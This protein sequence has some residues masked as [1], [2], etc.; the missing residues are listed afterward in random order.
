MKKKIVPIK[1][2]IKEVEKLSKYQNLNK[3]VLNKFSDLTKSQKDYI[4]KISTNSIKKKFENNNLSIDD[5]CK[6]KDLLNEKKNYIKYENTINDIINKNYEN[7]NFR[8]KLRQRKI[9]AIL[10]TGSLIAILSS[11]LFLNNKKAE[12]NHHTILIN[13]EETTKNIENYTKNEEEINTTEFIEEPNTESTTEYI[14]ETTKETIEHIEETTT[15]SVTEN[16]SNENIEN[17]TEYIQFEDD[18]IDYDIFSGLQNYYDSA[19]TYIDILEDTITDS[20]KREE[21]KENAKIKIT[22]Y[23]DFIFYGSEI[24]GVTFNELKDEEKEKI[25]AQLQKLDK[26]VSESDPDYKEKMGERYSVIK[27]FG[28]LTLNNASNKIKEKVGEEY[29]N[30]AGDTKDAIVDSGKDTSKALKNTISNLY[31]DWK[32]DEK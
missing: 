22:Q 31:Q 4:S 19:N 9:A 2:I 32:N 21:T 11:N 3:N 30:A 18:F 13:N 7:V 12:K 20:E 10:A 15:E 14:N 24:N 29:Y 26:L 16:Y 28:S 1:K 23:I 6:Y 25:Y 27:D 8:K 17:T 5:Y